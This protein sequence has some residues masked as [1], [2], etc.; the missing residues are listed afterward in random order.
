MSAI[1][2]DELE[3]FHAAQREA[4]RAASTLNHQVQVLTAAFR[5]AARKG[6][7]RHSPIS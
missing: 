2:E 3:A 4:G 6:Y 7:V 1:T 5:W